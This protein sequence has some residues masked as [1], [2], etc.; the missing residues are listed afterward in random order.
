MI[1]DEIKVLII[2]RGKSLRGGGGAERRFIR[3]LDF[4]NRSDIKLLTNKEFAESIFE[5]GILKNKD[6]II[7]PPKIMSI[8]KFNIWLIR[9]INKI[10]P[11]II[12]LPLIQKS[13]IPFYIW[14]NFFNNNIEV[15]SSI[16]W[17]RYLSTSSINYFNLLVGDLIYRKS[18]YIDVLYPSITKSK[19]IHKYLSKIRITPCSFTDYNIFKPSV[20][21]ENIIIF[22]GRLISEKNPFLFLYAI[23]ELKRTYPELIS[24]WKFYILGKGKLENR[25]RKFIYLNSLENNVE[26]KSLYSTHEYFS[27]SKIFVSLQYPTNYPSQSLLEAMA[28]ENAVIATDDE[29]TRLLIDENCG[30]LIKN[31][32]ADL[33]NALIKLMGDENLRQKLA[34][35][36]REKVINQHRIEIFA[37]YITEIW[38]NVES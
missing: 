5:S 6:S 16:V 35:R 24:N 21:K 31:N 28:T 12:H 17:S 3:L 4:L 25:I 15:T 23:R 34:K 27:K 33:V 30:I 14:L 7:F 13:L 1:T 22:A 8:I 11:K 37:K 36:A 32:V 19:L 29:D 9:T 18:K 38:D 20:I 26:L 10:K 2:I